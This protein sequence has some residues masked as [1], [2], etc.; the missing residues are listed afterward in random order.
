MIFQQY[1]SFPHLTVMDNVLFGLEI[2]K[3]EI[4]LSAADVPNA[5]ESLF[6]R[7]AFRGTKTNIPISFPEDSNNALR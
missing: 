5:R 3:D 1:S 2:N 4:K 7:S 6:N